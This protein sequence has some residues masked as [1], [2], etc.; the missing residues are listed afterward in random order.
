M[1]VETVSVLIA[2]GCL[3]AF[4]VHR[5]RVANRE[6]DLIIQDCKAPDTTPASTVTPSPKGNHIR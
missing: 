4:A 6:I 2:I 1:H 5:L 3:I